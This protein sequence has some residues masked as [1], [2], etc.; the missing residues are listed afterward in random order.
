LPSLDRL[1]AENLALRR[2]CALYEQLEQFRQQSTMRL[3]EPA[4]LFVNWRAGVRAD[5]APDRPV[6]LSAPLI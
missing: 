5:Q 1:R 2:R 4:P 3:D 6:C